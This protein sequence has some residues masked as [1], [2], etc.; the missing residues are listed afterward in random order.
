MRYGELE[1][2]SDGRF[3]LRFERTLRHAPEKVWAAITEPEH[4]KHWFPSTIEG[5]RTVGA[6]LVFRFP[7]GV[8]DPVQGEIARL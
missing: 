3:Q 2:L 8:V 1:Q 5:D 4:L 7:H 6:P